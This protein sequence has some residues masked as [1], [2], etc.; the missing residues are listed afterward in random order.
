MPYRENWSEIKSVY[1][2]W[3]NHR[4]DRPVFQVSSPAAGASTAD[5]FDWWLFLE[6]KDKMETL[7]QYL[8]RYPDHLYFGGEAFPSA[9]PNLGPGVLASYFSGYLEYNN[10]TRTS[11]FE[12]AHTREE[13]EAMSFHGNEAWWRYTQNITRLC[14]ETAKGRFLV[15]MTDIGGILDVLASLRGAENL[16]MDLIEAP[17]FVHLMR[18]RIVEAWHRAYDDLARIIAGTQDGVSSWLGVWAPTSYYPLQCDFCAMI[19]PEMFE[20]FVAPDV[21]EQCRR[22]GHAIY[23]LDGPGQIP[24]LE[25]LLDIPELDGIQWVPGSGNPACDAAVWFPMYRRILERGK[26]LVLQGFENP[27]SIPA[28]LDALPYP[29]LLLSVCFS[30]EAE[31]RDFLKAVRS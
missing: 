1:E 4:L 29:G 17:E 12:K 14:V 31:A 20:T 16:L 27:W 19:S 7:R 15:G 28:L 8:E 11:W 24:H 13:V 3:W 18:G 5:F 25:L 30:R 26:S 10:E 6:H 2:A 21:Q 9:F 22:L 23:H